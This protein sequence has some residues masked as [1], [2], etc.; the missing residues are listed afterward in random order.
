[1]NSFNPLARRDLLDSIQIDNE[2]P[3]EQ[4]TE[5]PG[6]TI[7]L[8]PFGVRSL[9]ATTFDWGRNWISLLGNNGSNNSN[10]NGAT[11][12]ALQG[13]GFLPT[14]VYNDESRRDP[15]AYGIFPALLDGQRVR[16]RLDS[17]SPRCLVSAEFVKGMDIDREQLP[18]VSGLGGLQFK[19]VGKVSLLLD[20]ILDRRDRALIE[21]IVLPIAIPSPVIGLDGMGILGIR[22]EHNRRES[23]FCYIPRRA[24]SLTIRDVMDAAADVTGED[25]RRVLRSKLHQLAYG[26][27]D[28]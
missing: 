6:T 28:N 3:Q 24:D 11:N 22:T 21:F 7:M 1:M 8:K 23:S 18:V 27:N 12:N 17:G 16:I 26:D 5:D 2:E 9:L 15:K 25:W 14:T 20:L 19:S 13:F 4:P 10:N